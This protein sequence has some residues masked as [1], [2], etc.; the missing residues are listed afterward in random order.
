MFLAERSK[1]KGSHFECRLFRK[2]LALKETELLC[3]H[4]ERRT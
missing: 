3:T 2:E 1:Q 4:F